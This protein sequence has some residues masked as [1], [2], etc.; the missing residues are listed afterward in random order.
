M[1]SNTTYAPQKTADFI[2]TQLRFNAQGVSTTISH[3]T[4]GNLDYLLADDCLITGAW[5]ISNNGNFGDKA[6]F[7]VLDTSTGT[8]SGTPY[9]PLNQFISNWYFPPTTETQFDMVYPAKIYTGM[10]LRL[11]YTSTGSSD[12]FVAINYK[13][14]KVLS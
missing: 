9:A 10:T 8:Y 5:V 3:G 7:Q 6:N 2:G 14:H 11:I 12:V 1:P 13:L 4:T